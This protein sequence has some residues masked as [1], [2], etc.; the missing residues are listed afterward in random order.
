MT[1]EERA[2]CCDDE[3]SGAHGARR[4]TVDQETSQRLADTFGGLADPTRARLIGLLADNELC[5][6]ELSE[7]LDMSMSAISHQLALLRRLRI[8]RRR[9]EGRHIYYSVDDDHIRA[10]FRAGLDHVAH[11]WPADSSNEA[12]LSLEPDVAAS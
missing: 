6:G 8:V 12:L 5:V 11:L 2:V 3:H 4:W 1:V 10:I 9:R 7:A